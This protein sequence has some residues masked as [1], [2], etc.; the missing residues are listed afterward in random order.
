MIVVPNKLHFQGA[1]SGRGI[2]Q[3]VLD[4]IFS[5]EQP[6]VFRPQ[7][8]LLIL[9]FQRSKFWLPEPAP[10]PLPMLFFLPTTVL[11]YLTHIPVRSDFDSNTVFSGWPSLTSIQ[12]DSP[13]HQ[14]S[15]ILTSLLF[16][17]S[18]AFIT[19]RTQNIFHLLNF[20]ILCPSPPEQKLQE[21]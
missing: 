1:L 12:N 13:P 21:G 9:S 19:T 17:S 7:I 11:H 4:K 18:L 10:G 16:F 14:Q 20:F 2:R 15:S 8:W 5:Q 3:E 6:S